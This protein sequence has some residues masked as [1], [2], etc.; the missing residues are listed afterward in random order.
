MSV[1]API[2]I[3]AIVAAVLISNF[4]KAQQ[5]E[6]A[7]LDAYNAAVALA[8]AGQYDEAIAA[9][10]GLGDY[11]DSTEQIANIQNQ[12][13]EEQYQA[14]VSIL[15]DGEYEEARDKFVELA[16]YKDSASIAQQLTNE[17]TSWDNAWE[18][19]YKGDLNPLLAVIYYLQYLMVNPEDEK[20]IK[21]LVPYIGAWEY[22]SGND[23]LLSIHGQNPSYYDKCLSISTEYT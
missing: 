5:E 19:Y 2:V 9:F 8:E 10:T 13:L 16:N 23:L 11:K 12:Q 4:V 6:A 1:A 18:A 21:F 15:E 7:R 3:V 22:F 14:A 17:I 20:N